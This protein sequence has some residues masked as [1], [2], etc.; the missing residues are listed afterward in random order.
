MEKRLDKEVALLVFQCPGR[1]LLNGPN[2]SFVG[3]LN[4]EIGER[5]PLDASRALD[6]LFLLGEKT[7]FCPFGA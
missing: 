2:S 5:E 4:H 1:M 7:G 6:S 3:M